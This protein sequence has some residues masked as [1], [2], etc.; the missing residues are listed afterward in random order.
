[1]APGTRL[2]IV[3]GKIGTEAD[4]G[5]FRE[6]G[7]EREL[8][9][10]F[11][12]GVGFIGAAGK[13]VKPVTGR[14]SQSPQSALQSSSRVEEWNQPLNA[15]DG[16]G[17]EGTGNAGN[18]GKGSAQ[19]AGD[20]FGGDEEAGARGSHVT[21]STPVVVSTVTAAMVAWPETAISW[22]GTK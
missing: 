11:A 10:G 18:G 5:D 21:S 3:G 9:A 1:M 20:G 13:G 8:A 7:A 4:G 15:G 16:D 6:A 14:L 17:L 22:S 12:G 19:G 2:E